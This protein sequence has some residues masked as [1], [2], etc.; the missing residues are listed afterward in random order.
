MYHHLRKTFSSPATALSSGQQSL[1][2][3]QLLCLS[4]SESGPLSRVIQILSSS[5]KRSQLLLNIPLSKYRR[6]GLYPMVILP[7]EDDGKV[8]EAVGSHLDPLLPMFAFLRCWMCY[9]GGTQALPIG[10]I[11]SRF[12]VPPSPALLPHYIHNSSPFRPYSVIP[13]AILGVLRHEQPDGGVF[14]ASGSRPHSICLPC[15]PPPRE[16]KISSHS[17]PISFVPGSFL[18]LFNP[19]NPMVK[20]SK[21]PDLCRMRYREFSRLVR[22]EM[23]IT[24]ERETP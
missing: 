6:P 18:G 11:A 16:L 15:P 22:F 23:L 21:P 10:L 12:R 20:V 13:D 24:L 3:H 8:F 9:T 2:N 4:P 19:L 7:S 5:S 1:D 17:T 14:K